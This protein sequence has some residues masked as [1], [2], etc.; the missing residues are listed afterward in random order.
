MNKDS[1]DVYNYVDIDGSIG[2]DSTT[3]INNRLQIAENMEVLME[4]THDEPAVLTHKD[5]PNMKIVIDT[6]DE[7]L[8]LDD[9]R[10]FVHDV[11]DLLT[12]YCV[13]KKDTT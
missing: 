8:N 3:M 5:F 9:L 11:D 7:S 1:N 13:T 2:I 4:I 6:K 12:K 10:N